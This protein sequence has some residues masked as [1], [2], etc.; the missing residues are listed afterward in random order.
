[1]GSSINV[2]SDRNELIGMRLTRDVLGEKGKLLA[3]AYSIINDEVLS[4]LRMRGLSLSTHDVM[5]A[6]PFV[7]LTLSENEVMI[8]EVTNHVRDIFLDIRRTKKIPLLVIR[9][10][11][12][13]IIQHIVTRADLFDLL[14][15]MQSKDDYLYRHSLA[16]SIVATILGQWLDLSESELMQ[17]TTAALLHNVGEMQIPE[18]ILNKRSNLDDEEREL[19]RKHVTIGYEMIKNTVGMNHKQS[20]AALQHH[21]RLDGLGYP[22]GL[23]GIRIEQYSRIVAV[24][25]V[26]HAIASKRLYQEPMP[27]HKVLSQMEEES[28]GRLDPAIVQTFISKMM[29]HAIGHQVRLSDGQHGRI[30]YINAN[31]MTRPLVQLTEGFIDLSQQRELNIEQLII[32][33]EPADESKQ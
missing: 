26:F 1:M 16:V 11:I 6:G 14:A 7:N 24:A 5:F 18:H 27:F 19:M 29:Q 32:T 15:A 25:D 4:T 9:K 13:P 22:L 33:N 23:P 28:F 3:P 21:E 10:Q 20:L 12:L 8:D 30:V 31:N 17:L 2:P